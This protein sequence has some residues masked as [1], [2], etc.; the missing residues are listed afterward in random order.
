MC[1]RRMLQA[2]ARVGHDPA[3]RV[4]QAAGPTGSGHHQSAVRL[5]SLHEVRRGAGARRPAA[6]ARA[7]QA[8][9]RRSGA[10][11]DQEQLDVYCRAAVERRRRNERAPRG[12]GPRQPQVPASLSRAMQLRRPRGWTPRGR[13]S[14]HDPRTCPMPLGE[15]VLGR[16]AEDPLLRRL[17]GAVAARIAA[18]CPRH[19]G[20]R[21]DRLDERRRCDA[22]EAGLRIVG[23][24][25]ED[26]DCMLTCERNNDCPQEEVKTECRLFDSA[27]ATRRSGSCAGAVEIRRRRRGTSGAASAVALARPL[28]GAGAKPLARRGRA[29]AV[30]ASSQRRAPPRSRV[31]SGPPRPDVRIDT[32]M[33]ALYCRVGASGGGGAFSRRGRRR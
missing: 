29:G 3:L 31:A 33:R 5:Q 27:A 10:C 17:R 8:G 6:P 14:Q 2:A 32:P 28:M 4:T 13:R 9:H 21:N 7:V 15:H 1:A 19:R 24:I 18:A 30:R 12:P 26:L 16:M 11:D 20:P 23:R 22:L 25:V